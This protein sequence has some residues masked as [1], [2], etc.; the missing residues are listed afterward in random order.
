MSKDFPAPDWNKLVPTVVLVCAA[1]VLFHDISGAMV[2][3]RALHRESVW[4]EGLQAARTM[5]HQIE[6]NMR[7]A[8]MPPCAGIAP[9]VSPRGL[10]LRCDAGRVRISGVTQQGGTLEGQLLLEPRPLTSPSAPST[11]TSRAAWAWGCR[12]EGVDERSVPHVCAR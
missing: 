3:Y 1:L 8:A 2:E 9:A 5:R 11:S 7:M 6:S 12:A 4:M 10:E